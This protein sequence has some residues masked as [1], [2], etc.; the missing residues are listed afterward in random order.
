MVLP[1]CFHSTTF[2]KKANK[3]TEKFL[4]SAHVSRNLWQLGRMTMSCASSCRLNCF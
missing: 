3:V 1:S 2:Y 4:F